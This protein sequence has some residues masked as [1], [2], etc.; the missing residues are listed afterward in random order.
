MIVEEDVNAPVAV[1]IEPGD[2]YSTPP[3]YFQAEYGPTGTGR[4]KSPGAASGIGI[5]SVVREARGR[6][7]SAKIVGSS[8]AAKSR[9]MAAT[10]LQS[11][12][13][14]LPSKHNVDSRCDRSV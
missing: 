9:R 13:L 10:M 3:R 8:V 11:Q 2:A 7:Q 6:V 1:L 5:A 12:Q 4:W 14:Q